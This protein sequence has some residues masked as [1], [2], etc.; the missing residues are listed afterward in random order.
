KEFPA[1]YALLACPEDTDLTQVNDVLLRL[2]EAFGVDGKVA[3]I[4]PQLAQTLGSLDLLQQ[5]GVLE[6]L[7]NIE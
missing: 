6:I 2:S 5:Q 1:I 3:L 7:Y 4:W